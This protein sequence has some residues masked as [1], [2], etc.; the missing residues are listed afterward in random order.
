MRK[1]T[2]TEYDPD[3]S[4]RQ[5]VSAILSEQERGRM[6]D[7]VDGVKQAAIDYLEHTQR[8]TTYT[9]VPIIAGKNQDPIVLGEITKS[10]F[11]YL[12]DY[13]MVRREPGRSI[14]DA[15]LV[16]A[17]ETC[18]LCGGVGQARTIDHY[19]PKANYPQF[20]VLP[21]NLIPACRDCNSDK[22]NPII[23]EAKKQHFHPY[24]DQACFYEEP[25]VVAVV[26]HELPCAVTYSASPPEQWTTL[27]KE[28]ATNHFNFFN[29]S[30]RYSIRAAEELAIL[31]HQRRGFLRDFTPEAFAQFLQ[32]IADSPDL[33][34]NHWKKVM[35]KALALDD[36]FCRAEF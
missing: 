3:Y 13:Y 21:Y 36:W 2:I 14:Y 1:M 25:W 5:C 35:Y 17:N 4:Y 28:R 24:Y 26:S 20:S 8:A 19:L 18:P 11:V 15:I 30:K 32:S 7:Q 27:N 22:K 33:F 34:P 9:I 10:E 12:Y 29:I 6:L 16:A 31:V 23:T